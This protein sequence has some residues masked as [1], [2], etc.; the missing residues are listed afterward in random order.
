QT[1]VDD[2]DGR[3]DELPILTES[4]REQLIK[5]WNATEHYYPKDRTIVE[6]I[7][8][9]VVK[10]PNAP[11]VSTDSSLLSY[12]ELDRRSNSLAWRLH[13]TGVGRD[14][15]IGIWL[16]RSAETIIALLGV[17]KAGAAYVPLDLEYPRDRVRFMLEDARVRAVITQESLV[18]L[19]PD[20]APDLVVIN[21]AEQDH[22]PKV[23][24]L[25]EDLAYIIYTSGSTGVPKGV[26]VPHRALLNSTWARLLYYEEAVERF[27]L[28]SPF[29]FDSSVAGIFWT[30]CTGGCLE[31]ASRD[32]IGIP[33]ELASEIERKQIT[34]L[35]TVPS[36]FTY[37]LE[38]LN[39]GATRLRVA[40][41]AGEPCPPA[42]VEQHFQQ[43]TET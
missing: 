33:M 37:L 10:T 17:L 11:A 40:I 22:P 12:A 6:L 26:A 30:L 2:P 32:S 42:L 1:L 5:T 36:L 16:D 27:L 31:I 34:H 20:P 24:I 8:E 41:V 13:E 43:L 38:V 7:H 3:I 18:S 39:P 25:P 4:E 15:R 21:Q 35:L 19:L 23:Q 29:T 14:D 9:Q 28:V